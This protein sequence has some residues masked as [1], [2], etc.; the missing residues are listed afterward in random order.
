[1]C[2]VESFSGNF[3]DECLNQN[4]FVSPAD[5]GRAIGSW[6]LDYTTGAGPAA[7]LEI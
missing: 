7:R 6:R 3:R 1:M 2:F 4:G 5:T